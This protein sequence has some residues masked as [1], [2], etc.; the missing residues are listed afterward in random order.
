V[1]SATSRAGLLGRA[2]GAVRVVRLPHGS[3]G[4][5]RLGLGQRARDGR[6]AARAAQ[7]GQGSGRRP[8]RPR[9]PAQE[10]AHRR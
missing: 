6:L 7:A 1:K 9:Q 4:L 8:S 5:A 10:A 3:G 2:L